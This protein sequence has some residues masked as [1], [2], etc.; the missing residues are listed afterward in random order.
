MKKREFL[1]SSALLASGIAF[2]PSCLSNTTQQSK[3]FRTAHIGLGFQG[4]ED[5]RDISS[6]ELVDVVALCDVDSDNLATAH[7]KYP[8]A[9]TFVDYR[10]MFEEMSNEI[11]AVI[12][13]TPDHTHA[14]ASMMAMEKNKPVYCQKPLTH[15][16]AS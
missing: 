13:S 9:K 1:K 14:P 2:L 7:K 4:M 6:H 10:K 3:R 8:N 5:I 16:P 15:N 12:V 11:D